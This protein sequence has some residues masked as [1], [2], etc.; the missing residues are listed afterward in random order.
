MPEITGVDQEPPDKHKNEHEIDYVTK[1][2]SNPIEDAFQVND[3]PQTQDKEPAQLLD[4]LV[5]APTWRS[6]RFKKPFS[7]IVPSFSEEKYDTS[8]TLINW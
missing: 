1:E 5:P 6:T 8:A 2:V 3:D 7:C 4:A